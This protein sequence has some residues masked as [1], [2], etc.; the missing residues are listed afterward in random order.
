M[1]AL[2]R[3]LAETT[4]HLQ[5]QGARCLPR[6]KV[7]ALKGR[8]PERPGG[9]GK[10]YPVPITQTQLT[11]GKTKSNPLLCQSHVCCEVQT[12]TGPL[13]KWG[14][15]GILHLDD[16]SDPNNPDSPLVRD[17][18][19]SKH[20]IG[21]S[22]HANCIIPSAPVDVHLRLHRHHHHPFCFPKDHWVWWSVWYR[23][24]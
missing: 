2:Y 3:L 24:T 17:V 10:G 15:G 4:P 19:I 23:R 9:R 20:P 14:K 21:Q 7:K 16:P 12:G 5:V 11:P 8:Q 1:A 22:A 13:L 6:E 18:L